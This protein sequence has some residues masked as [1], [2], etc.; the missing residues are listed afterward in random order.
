[1]PLTRNL[2]IE[3]DDFAEVPPKK[4]K[5]LS[6]GEAVRLRGAYVIRCEEVIKDGQGEVIEIRASLDPET[7]GAN[8]TGY[9]PKGVIH[10]V[11]ADQ[12]V[13]CEVRV[14]DRLFTEPNPEAD[15]E[16]DFHQCIN[17]E[18]LVVCADARVEI[19]LKDVAVESRFQFE[20]QGYFCV[21]PDSDEHRLVFNRTVGL[22][23]SWAKLKGK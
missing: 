6:P 15:K 3:R 19:G 5:R 23:D 11:S 17:P 13:P 2:L 1:M 12:S 20:R 16:R 22:R 8:P 4:W 7:R 18:S 10:W 14:Y 9:K 21:D